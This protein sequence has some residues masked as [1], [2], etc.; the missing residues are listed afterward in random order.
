MAA[1]LTSGDRRVRATVV[2]T[3]IV[4][5]GA[6][7]TPPASSQSAGSLTRTPA[8]REL[9]A[10]IA[11]NPLFT[12]WTAPFGAPPL[13]RIEAVHFTPA[14]EHAMAVHRQEIAAIT[15]TAQAPS[16][17]NTI[18]ALEL[19]GADLSRVQ[20]VF[21]VLTSSATNDDLRAI[22][23]E[24]S[25]R[26]A[27][28][29]NA[30]MLDPELFARVADLHGRR[31]QLDLTP[32]QARVLERTYLQ[33]ERAGAKLAG[34]DRERL[35]AINEELATL[36]TTFSQN[37]QTD[38]ERFVL[39][40]EGEAD[41][42]G[43]PPAV[44]SAAAQAASDRGLD[45]QYAITLAR[46]SFEPFMTFST[47]RDLRERLFQAWT[48]RGG[49]GNEFDNEATIRRILQLRLE[50]ANLL[51]Y[52]N[53]AARRRPRRC[54]TRCGRARSPRPSGRPPRFTR[55]WR[56]R[57]PRMRSRPGT[58]GTTRRRPA[59]SC[60]PSTRTRSSSTS[61]WTTS[62]RRSSRWPSGCSASR[63]PSAATSPSTTRTCASGR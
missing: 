13:D 34:A 29:G 39:V 50:K 59:P 53:W 62:C 26:L 1:I 7:G 23:R 14:F 45:G 35:A 27:A 25:P 36:S 9:P 6:L 56:A 18:D 24:M 55:S 63:S 20:R 28:H 2:A 8:E 15:A 44:L 58:G 32:E 43:L 37:V 40:L 16:F 10:A 5:L 41:R 60:T 51:G 12:E 38:A 54:W 31:D 21:G 17:R 3:I 57:V 19:A 11:D 4:S 47:R 22:E 42:A 30:I 46:S 49:N 61:R 52:D 48:N 33:F